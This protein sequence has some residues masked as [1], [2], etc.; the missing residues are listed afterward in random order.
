VVDYAECY[1]RVCPRSD[2]APLG[3]ALAAGRLQA[4]TAFSG[5][6]LDNLLDLLGP[7]AESIRALPLFVPHARIARHAQTL[8]FAQVIATAPGEDGLLAGLV[9]YFG[10]D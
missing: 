2:P 4:I 9:E 5:E 10:H 1:R 3:E 7:A 6:T 8:N